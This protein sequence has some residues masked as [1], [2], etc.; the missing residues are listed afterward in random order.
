LLFFTV[1]DN[2]VIHASSL[3]VDTPMWSQPMYHPA[4]IYLF[5]LFLTQY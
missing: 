2:Y 1:I 5:Y 3:P 4:N